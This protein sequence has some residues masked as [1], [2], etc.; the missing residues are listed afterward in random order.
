MTIKQ[1]FLSALSAIAILALPS[2]SSTDDTTSYS[3]TFQNDPYF[4]IRAFVERGDRF[5]LVPT[6]VLR[7]TTDSSEYSVGYFW[8]TDLINDDSNDTTRF[9]GEDASINDGSYILVVPDTLAT[10]IVT[11]AAYA[12]G[13]YD[14]STYQYSTIV[15]EEETLTNLGLDSTKTFIDQRDGTRYFYSQVGNTQWMS[16]NLAYGGTSEK[17]LGNPFGDCE[18]MNGILGRLYTW[19]EVQTAC[20]DGWRLPNQNDFNNLARI[21]DSNASYT[22]DESMPGLSCHFMSDVYFNGEK[23]W[24][25]WPKVKI[26]NAFGTCMMPVGYAIITDGSYDYIGTN[27]RATMWTSDTYGNKG[28]I[29]YIYADD[30]D[31][32]S[33]AAEKETFAATAR[34]VRDI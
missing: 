30:P 23:L 11:C 33:F 13:Y 26:D 21:Y 22:P 6:K 24:E 32:R 17:V 7:S 3:D 28:I 14:S 29:K 19:E 27:Y 10:I 25:Y 12:D 5:L 2:C 1:I 18:V 15:D 9:E 34:C 4:N 16:K 31:L 8:S 20:P